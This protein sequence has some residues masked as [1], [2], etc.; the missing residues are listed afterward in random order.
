MAAAPLACSVRPANLGTTIA[1][2]MPRITST[3]S[4]STSVNPWRTS[5]HRRQRGAPRDRNGPRGRLGSQRIPMHRHGGIDLD[6]PLPARPLRAGTASRSVPVA[7]RARHGGGV[8]MRPVFPCSRNGVLIVGNEALH[9][10]P[11]PDLKLR[12]M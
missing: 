9:L 3:S 2:K 6:I 10:G 5:R 11:F 1:A 7:R 8:E 4:N 12:L